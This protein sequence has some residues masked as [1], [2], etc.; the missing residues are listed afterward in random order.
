[1][2]FGLTMAGISAK[3]A[4]KTENKYKYNGKELQNKEFSDGGGLELYDYGARMQDP[5]IGRWHAIDPLSELYRKWSPYIYAVNNPIRFIDPDGMKVTAIN[6]GVR[7]E[8]LEDITAFLNTQKGSESNKSDPGPWEMF[9]EFLKTLLSRPHDKESAERKQEAQGVANEIGEK[10]QKL[11]EAE[12]KIFENVPGP[13]FVYIGRD[14]ADGKFLNAGMGMAFS[15]IGNAFRSSS[16]ILGMSAGQLQS[17]FKHA[18]DFGVVGNY[19]K[20]NASKFS[21]AIN[22]F[23][24]S[25]G[26]QVINGTYR[27]TPVIHYLNPNTGL[28]VISSPT[29]QFISGWKLNPEQLQNVIRRGSL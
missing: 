21:S 29:G 13:N 10:A 20:A 6:G 5:Q 25:E 2:P 11:D 23:I 27:G 9:K 28:N 16:S 22:Q 14:L 7:I 19:S 3:G 24:N 8:G 12:R 1:Y 4:G 17:K 26:V 15:G 18:V